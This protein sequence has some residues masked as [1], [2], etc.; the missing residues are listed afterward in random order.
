MW[1]PALA[2]DSPPSCAANRL[3]K[4][5]HR[6]LKAVIICHADQR[7]TEALP[8]VLR[9]RTTF[10]E[11]LQASVAEL[12][13]GKPLRIP[14]EILISSA[15]PVDPALL[16]TELCQHMA[17]LRPVSAARH[18]SLA[19]FMHEDL[20]KC[21]H[22]FLRQDATCQALEPPYSGPYQVLSWRD[23]RLQLL[24][25]GRPVTVSANG[26]A[27]LRPEQDQLR[28]QPEPTSH[29]TACH[30]TTAP[31]KNYTLWSP[32]TFPLSLQ[33]LSN[34]LHGVVMWELP[35]AMDKHRVRCYEVNTHSHSN[36]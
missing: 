30:T 21:T 28:E 12:M 25:R 16:I 35:T 19:T 9:I 29:S 36:G 1:H 34:H 5:F 15:N 13:Y 17:H 18:V 20:E 31:Y 23:K 14:G 10:K 2:N 8:L 6:T 22:V 32:R 26:Q 3:M 11:D 7:W 33:H 27:S 24:V 4:R